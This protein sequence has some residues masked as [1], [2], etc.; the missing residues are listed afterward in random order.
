MSMAISFTCSCGKVGKVKEE[1]AGRKIRC[2]DCRTVFVVP[3]PTE[4][5]DVDQ[6]AADLLLS[7]SPRE[8]SPAR[9]ESPP[10]ERREEATQPLPARVPPRKPIDMT[11]P[12]APPRPKKEAAPR[13]ERTPIAFEEG[14]FGSLNAGVIGGF[15]TMLIAIVWLVVGMAAGRIFIYAPVLFVFGFIAMIRGFFNRE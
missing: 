8:E 7:D 11:P 13:S 14:W 3:A 10:L 5:R 12:K 6:E 15:L 9:E 2:P 1:F 4:E